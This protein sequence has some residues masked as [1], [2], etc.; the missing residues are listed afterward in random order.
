MS[1]RNCVAIGF[2]SLGDSL[3]SFSV[4]QA[5]ILGS[6]PSLPSLGS[7]ATEI[8]AEGR[9]ILGQRLTYSQ[10]KVLCSAWRLDKPT[11][12]TMVIFSNP[13]PTIR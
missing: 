4:E 7:M 13:A 1:K 12:R 6:H 10:A 9:T 3:Y 5:A 8:L 2:P 11:R